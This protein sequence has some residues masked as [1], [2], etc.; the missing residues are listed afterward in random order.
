M[1]TAG[2]SGT[3]LLKKLG[4]KDETRLLMLHAPDNYFT[5]LEKDVTAQICKKNELPGLVHLFADNMRVFE[6]EMMALQPVWIQNATVTIWVS[7]YKKSG[8]KATDLTEDII[9]NYALTNGLVDV[10]VCAV[11]DLWSGL[12]LVV[13]LRLRGKDKKSNRG[14]QP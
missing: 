1:T 4:I 6:M 2:Y 14:S 7:W 5:L 9:R 13:P 3:P 12:K 11:S 10:K 8:G